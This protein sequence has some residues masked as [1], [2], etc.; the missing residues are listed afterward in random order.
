MYYHIMPAQQ[1]QHVT[2]IMMN[3]IIMIMIT[4]IITITITITVFVIIFIIIT[5]IIDYY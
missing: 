1:K 3:T 2:I 4:F 5:I